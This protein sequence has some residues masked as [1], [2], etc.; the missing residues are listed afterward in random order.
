MSFKRRCDAA[1]LIVSV[2]A[3]TLLG[4]CMSPTRDPAL[5]KAINA[6]ARTLMSALPPGVYEDV[7]KENWPDA[8]ASLEP[9]RVVVRPDGADII[10]KVFFDDSW[11]YFVPRTAEHSPMPAERFSNLGQGVYWYHFS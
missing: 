7:P 9:E 11:G 1:A 10:L 3:L 5:L 8:I 4:G 6:E 2:L